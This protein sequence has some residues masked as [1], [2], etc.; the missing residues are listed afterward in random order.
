M[1]NDRDLESEVE[2]L[3]RQSGALKERL[4]TN[5]QLMDAWASADDHFAQLRTASVALARAQTEAA[6][7]EL[8]ARWSSQKDLLISSFSVV[9]T[10]A[11]RL[12]GSSEPT[13]PRRA[14]VLL[15]SI[16]SS[17]RAAEELQ[18]GIREVEDLELRRLVG[19]FG[20]H[21]KRARLAFA[22]LERYLRRVYGGSE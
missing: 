12:A 16:S 14:E 1:A 6:K 5:Q 3:A 20:D 8:Q 11:L 4:Q 19:F 9:E 2:E 7:V 18:Q 13:S 21:L 15:A 22:E 10:M 17:L